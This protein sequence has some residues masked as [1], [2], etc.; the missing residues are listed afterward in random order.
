MPLPDNLPVL[1]AATVAVVVLLAL[2]I[3]LRAR[4]RRSTDEDLVLPPVRTDVSPE[5]ELR[6]LGITAPPRPRDPKTVRHPDF[7]EM[8]MPEPAEDDLAVA[9]P[10]TVP[11]MPPS[12]LSAKQGPRVRR[13]LP[14]EDLAPEEAQRGATDH[15]LQALQLAA[16]AHT[17]GLLQQSGGQST[18][19]Y[20]IVSLYSH[21]PFARSA[22][23]FTTRNA[24]VPPGEHHAVLHRV[25]ERGLPAET[26]RYYREEI[27]ALRGLLAMPLRAHGE[28]YVLLLDS[29]EEGRLD[30][31]RVRDLTEA[32]ARMLEQ[33][34]PAPESDAPLASTAPSEAPAPMPERPSRRAIIAEELARIG[35]AGLTLALVYVDALDAD[36][37]EDLRA[38]AEASFERRLKDAAPGSRVEQ[39]AEM[40][41]GVFLH[42][43]S[44]AVDA[45]VED[46]AQHLRADYPGARIAFGA[47]CVT[48]TGRSPEEVR[49]FA[50]RAL[51]QSYEAG[52]EPVILG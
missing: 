8:Y 52:G 41:F 5:D 2:L 30:A 26:L 1:I 10:P 20:T 39:F 12:V 14:T 25:G 27:S 16:G 43:T 45:W 34:R 17:V 40:T 44:E 13:P 36:A 4:R 3:V 24:L 51:A 11:P 50:E 35:D 19:R 31:G 49:A 46:A 32:T 15:L 47:A 23:S 42:D 9:T 21:S 18:Y 38:Q 29:K 48:D 6:S 37:G 33:L 7:P 22:G 28:D